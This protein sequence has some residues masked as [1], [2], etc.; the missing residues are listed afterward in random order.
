YKKFSPL[1]REGDY[2]KITSAAENGECDAWVSVGRDKKNALVTFVQIF[3]HPN[4]KTRMIRIPGLD[5]GKTYTVTWPDEDQ[6][7]YPPLKLS[8]TTIMN[9]GIPIRRD[10]GDFQAQLIYLE[11]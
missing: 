3:N 1:V 9:A 2:Y 11:S 8:G 5:E 6:E 4:F 7:K 10:W